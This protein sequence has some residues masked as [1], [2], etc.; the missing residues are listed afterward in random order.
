VIIKSNKILSKYNDSS[1]KSLENKSK[2]N[3]KQYPYKDV[4]QKIK[5]KADL[6]E[7]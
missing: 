3:I 4:L 5:I 6:N 2:I 7:P 1:N